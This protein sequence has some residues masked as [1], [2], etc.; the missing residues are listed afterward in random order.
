MVYPVFKE[1]SIEARC[2]EDIKQFICICKMKDQY[3]ED[4]DMDTHAM[5]DEFNKCLQS[6]TNITNEVTRVD[7]SLQLDGLDTKSNLDI[8]IDNL[9]NAIAAILIENNKK[10]EDFDYSH[11][12]GHFQSDIQRKL[13]ILRTYVF[14][15]LLIFATKIMKSETLFNDIYNESSTYKRVWR[16]EV[17]A[18]E[19]EEF[20]MGIFGSLTPTSDIDIG[21]SY[22]GKTSGFAALAYVVAIFEDMFKIFMGKSSLQLDIEPYADMYILPNPNNDVENPYIFYLDTSEFDQNDFKQILPYVKT[23]ILRNYVFAKLH[24]E[25]NS[26]IDTS[27]HVNNIVTDFIKNNGWKTTI[28]FFKSHTLSAVHKNVPINYYAFNTLFESSVELLKQ[29]DP[30]T[31]DSTDM[32][33]SYMTKDYDISREDYYKSVEDAEKYLALNIKPKVFSG[34]KLSKQMIIDIMQKIG[35][36]L[37]WRA[38]SYTCGPTIMHVVRVLQANKNNPNKYKT[39]TPVC[40]YPYK[41]PMCS[42]GPYGFMMS[43]ME[44]LGYIYRFNLTY[45]CDVCNAITPKR[46]ALPFNCAK[47]IKKYK[48][49]NERIQNAVEYIIVKLKQKGGS[50][51]RRSKQTLRKRGGKRHTRKPKKH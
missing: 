51:K 8:C 42:L 25:H 38:E 19:L 1:D 18:S 29:N 24:L 7:V 12:I 9:K 34:E 13:W 2:L 30:K 40:I 46:S 26:S 50:R 31:H 45:T 32:I 11:D 35:K 5:K 44:Q 49:Y 36:T 3:G 4:V 16:P 41:D 37:T 17:N 33:L 6:I 39:N 14:Y 15:Q 48:K 23:S 43:V 21:I 10:Y 22:T 28:D 47:C 20:K 27:T